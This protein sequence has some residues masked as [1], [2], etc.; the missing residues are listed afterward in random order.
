MKHL[1]RSMAI[2][3]SCR[4]NT[5]AGLLAFLLLL[6][7][8]RARTE[9]GGSPPK[10]EADKGLESLSRSPYY[11][12][13]SLYDEDGTIISPDDEPAA[14]YSPDRTCGKCHDTDRIRRGL[15]FNAATPGV[16]PGRRSQPWVLV[17]PDT[18]SQVPLSYRTW[19]GV[20]QPRDLG[21]GAWEFLHLF[22]RH[23][24]GNIDARTDGKAVDPE[25]RWEISGGLDIDCLACHSAD[26]NHNQAERAAQVE[27]QNYR[28]APTAS[29]GLATVRGDAA[30]LPEDYDPFAGPDP[31]HPEQ[32]PPKVLYDKTRFNADDR[33]HFA[34]TRRPS[35][36]RCYFCHT[37]REVG[38]GAPRDWAV[39]PDVH[40]ASGL[41]CTDC[42]RNGLDHRMV[43]GFEGESLAKAHPEIES[44][45]CRGCHLGGVSPGLPLRGR[46]G[47]P[48][49]RHA[50]LPAFH[51]DKLSCTA[52]HSGLRP[53]AATRHIQTS[54][55]HGLG[56]AR[57][58][59]RDD[60][61]P[62][63][64]EPVFLPDAAGRVRPYRAFWP[65]W[66]GRMVD[67]R[68]VPL[69]P[70]LVRDSL[71]DRLE[72]KA[73][74][75]REAWTPL[76]R[77]RIATTLK[78]LAARKEVAGEPVYVCAGRLYRIT[79][80]QLRETPYPGTGMSSWPIA[81][82]VRPAGQA[83][84]ATGCADCHAAGAPFFFGGIEV[85]PSVAG[86]PVRIGRLELMGGDR[87]LMRAW[88][89]VLAFRAP[90]IAVSAL[91]AFVV[92][93]TLIHYAFLGIAGLPR[94]PR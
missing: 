77:E 1:F 13:I 4:V 53:T 68:A 55:A 41:V 34:V 12:L 64:V 73:P 49:P 47:A 76:S 86:A 71:P 23:L 36:D 22:G 31:D 38:A 6:C 85:R 78:S 21:L 82:D 69:N 56:L 17:D 50:G 52:C 70:E 48:Y 27:R 54:R 43:R 60:A 16:P 89:R 33:V 74:D 63:I 14:P 19:P 5:L 35:P 51:L 18:V 67:G 9:E 75:E 92:L 87:R 28:W 58:G 79:D 90:A 2:A 72:R 83:L 45:S 80:G 59:R 11:H 40:V 29:S 62:W 37:N 93:G 61:L 10:P 7:G 24:P 46:R 66:W 20:F 81:H 25:A 91:S 8:G 84:G 32:Q 44:L 57:K 65:S 26:G 3:A 30:K 88:S 39:D 42:H 94:K 15:H